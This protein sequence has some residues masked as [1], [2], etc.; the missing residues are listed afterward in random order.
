LSVYF[1]SMSSKM[2]ES[3]KQ[4]LLKGDAL[5]GI[6]IS[7]SVPSLVEMFSQCGFDWLW[8]DFEHAGTSLETMQT[9]LASMNGSGCASLVRLPWNDIVWIKRVLDL[10][11]DGIIIPMVNS[12][13]DIQSAIQACRYPPEGVRG[14]GAGRASGYGLNLKEYLA[15]AN[16]KLVVV[17]QVETA[18]AVANIEDMVQEEGVDAFLIGPWDLSG[19]LGHLGD[20]EHPSVQEAI[21]KVVSA[22]AKAN[23]PLGIQ[24]G[25][26]AKTHHYMAKGMTLMATGADCALLG[27]AVKKHVADCRA[28]P[29]SS[30]A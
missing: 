21:D 30:P 29:A 1:F 17:C 11:P 4:R 8:L 9:M 18:E 16:R 26:P 23:K 28:C 13:K 15:T 3:F 22:C 20:L 10:G 2:Q 25:N 19:S 27:A 24:A 14:V 12:R 6:Y 7:F 5:F